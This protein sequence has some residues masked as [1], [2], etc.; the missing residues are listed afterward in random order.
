[1]VRGIM[2]MKKNKYIS[3]FIKDRL[4]ATV[5]FGLCFSLKDWNGY[6]E[7]LMEELCAEHWWE[8]INH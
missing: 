2:T 3:P 6:K 7:F 5:V 8:G 4:G 1:M